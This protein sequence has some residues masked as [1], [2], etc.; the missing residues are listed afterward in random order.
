METDNIFSD[1][2][3]IC[4]PVFF[5]QIAVV[6]V[7]IISQSGNIV[8]QCIQ[9]YIY[10]VT[11]IKVY[12]DSP[13][14]TGSGNTQ[15]LQT[16][17]QEVVYHLIFTGNRLD[18]LRMVLNMLHKTILIFTEFQKVRFF[19]C[20]LALSATIRALAIY[21]LG[22]RKERLTW[23]TIHSFIETFINIPFV[24]QL[25]EDL[26]NLSF[27]ILIRCTDKLIIGS[28]H[29]IPDSVD[30]C[31]YIIYKLFWCNACFFSL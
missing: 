6:A 20:R 22:S 28:V 3:Q 21:Q 12:R 25:F 7:Y 19:L 11:R 17:F 9:P 31:G 23:C 18:K 30:L 4:R 26:L 29:Q 15:I 2:V 5:I 8:A 1:Q 10:N 14:K 13:F 16:R 27:M 24:I